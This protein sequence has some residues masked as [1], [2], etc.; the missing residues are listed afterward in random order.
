MPSLATSLGPSTWQSMPGR[1]ASWRA[2]P[3]SKVGVA[4]LA[5]RL[6][7]SRARATPWAVPSARSKSARAAATLG[8]PIR[9]LL[10]E[11]VFFLGSGRLL[12]VW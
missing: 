2:A 12:V 11:G 4:W 6:A 7:H 1:L 8:T 10:S 5:G 3:A 9:A